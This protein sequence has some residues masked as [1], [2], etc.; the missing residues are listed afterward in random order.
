[1]PKDS[2]HTFIKDGAGVCKELESSKLCNK[3]CARINLLQSPEYNHFL[4]TSFQHE[5]L[6]TPYM[7]VS[8]I[9]ECLYVVSLKQ[10]LIP[11]KIM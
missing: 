5:P 11:R 6:S 3:W 9:T 8:H 2:Q 4:F 7:R 10:K 1:M